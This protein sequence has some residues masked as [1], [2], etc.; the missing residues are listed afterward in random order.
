MKAKKTVGFL[1]GA[2]ATIV[3]IIGFL[4]F[5]V[6]DG[7]TLVR[8]ANEG[9]QEQFI[10]LDE[11]EI[12]EAAYEF[13]KLNETECSVQVINY[14]EVTKAVIPSVGVIDGK[15]YRVTEVA[16]NGFM[17]C[18]NLVRVALNDNIRTIGDMAFADCEKLN[19]I[20]L[21]NVEEIGDNTFMLCPQLT[22]IVIPRSVNKMGDGV[23]LYNDTQVR[24]RAEAAGENWSE[25][26]NDDNENQE[27]EYGSTANQPLEL[28]PIYNRFIRSADNVIGYSFA[29]GQPWS[30]EYY[31][32]N[33]GDEAV[34]QKDGNLIIPAQYNGKDILAIAKNAFQGAKFNQLV[35]EYSEKEINIGTSAFLLTNGENITIN[36]N[37]AFNDMDAYGNKTVSNKIFFSSQIKSVVLPNTMTVL[38]DNMFGN[39]K[40]LTNIYFT[41]PKNTENIF[42]L[43]NECRQEYE[44]NEKDEDGN[45]EEGVVRL[46]GI[47]S[48]GNN[49]FSSTLKITKL[50]LY[51]ATTTMGQSVFARWSDN[52]QTI[53]VHNGGAVFGWDVNWNDSW[54]SQ[55]TNIKYDAYKV[56][57]KSE[58]G[59]IIEERL[60]DVGSAI[61][62]FPFVTKDGH[63]PNWICEE[64]DESTKFDESTIFSF[65]SDIKLTLKWTGTFYEV[66]LG[67]SGITVMAQFGQPMPTEDIYGN[68]LIPPTG[69]RGYGI[70]GYYY[71]ENGGGTQYYNSDMT[72]AHEWDMFEEKIYTLYANWII[73]EYKID[74][75][76]E[77]KDN[78]D[79][80]IYN[81]NPKTYTVEQ[82]VKFQNSIFIRESFN[83]YIIWDHADIPKGSTGDITV[84]GIYGR[85]YAS[86]TSSITIN[87]FKKAYIKLPASLNGNCVITLG[88]FVNMLE[89][90][91]VAGSTY[92]INIKIEAVTPNDDL[93][94]TNTNRVPDF[95]LHLRNLS[96][97]APVGTDAIVMDT[98]GAV[99]ASTCSLNLYTYGAVQITGGTAYL[100]TTGINKPLLAPMGCYAISCGILN[101]RSADNLRIVGGTGTDAAHGYLTAGIGGYGVYVKNNKVYIYCSNV[102]IK[103]G[104]GGRGANDPVKPGNGGAGG[105]AVTG[106]GD[107]KVY[108]IE[109]VTNVHL[110]VG[111]AGDSG[112]WLPMP[113]DPIDP[114]KPPINPPI[115]S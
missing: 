48:I 23:F 58:E 91:G 25:F 78:Y 37:V 56:T 107:A 15:E 35:V 55:F 38:V 28:E 67:D 8:A 99:F 13:I 68:K 34:S 69:A 31:T 9:Q 101:V 57:F 60:V 85:D 14:E 112:K 51:R 54:N 86:N 62:E 21:Y 75:V 94:N 30:D 82:E 49:A 89:I 108:K 98:E 5:R 47:E 104:T 53:F 97:Q 80:L 3:L 90:E 95:N 1:L 100:E 103:G 74:Y 72:S 81:T 17:S 33:K 102:V 40:N 41:E 7:K 52:A 66:N 79:L 20:N 83:T 10:V 73:I 43:V 65:D 50:H 45:I 113:V 76:L 32:I 64:F 115:T 39:C 26:W 46:S 84:Y 6:D 71:E 11:G 106:S 110:Y 93:F 70:T 29:D 42:N 111:D 4:W 59:E 16:T 87:E 77:A 44:K 27:V 105:H 114:I 96:I 18:P 63:D 109:G 19:R 24:V 36:R 22:E 92:N 12:V 88:A 2:L 61:G